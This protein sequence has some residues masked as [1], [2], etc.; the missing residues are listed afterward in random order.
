[1]GVHVTSSKE[2]K[3][4][5]ESPRL[6]QSGGKRLLKGINN[7][8]SD[9]VFEGDSLEIGS[10]VDCILTGEEGEY[11]RDYYESKLEKKPS[12]KV[13]AI[14]DIVFSGYHKHEVVELKTLEKECLEAADDIEYYKNRKAETRMKDILKFSDY[15][16]D[17][18]KSR[19]KTVLGMEQVAKIN[20]IV[21][22]L[23][24]ND[25]TFRYFDRDFQAG[26]KGNVDFF[27]QFPIYFEVDGVECKA[28]LDLVVVIRDENGVVLSIEPYDLK[29]MAG[30]TSTFMFSYKKWGYY[31]QAAWYTVALSKRFEVDM[32]KIEAFKFI[33]ES[34]TSPG[35]RPLVY[36][37]SPESLEIGL[38]GR[39]A[40][41]VA[42]TSDLFAKSSGTVSSVTISREV[43]GMDQIIELYKWH[44]E[45]GW[46]DDKFYFLKDQTGEDLTINWDNIT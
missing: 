29:T 16:E 2:I 44:Q 20:A 12:E 9:Q 1:M 36:T 3:E 24:S 35:I 21:K 28:L 40:I 39:A 41:E 7:F 32:D 17:L 6:S 34:T 10:A 42:N 13:K 30:S 46:E 14:I 5:F 8:L 33:V 27:Y 38:K 19:G 23:K 37:N 22:S 43:K 31:I 15:F 26:I 45:F 25:K 11:A 18:L 4:Y